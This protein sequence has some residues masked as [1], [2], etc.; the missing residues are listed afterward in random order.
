MLKPWHSNLVSSLIVWVKK[1]NEKILFNIKQDAHQLVGQAKCRASKIRPNAVE[2]W[3]FGRFSNFDKCRPEVA[4]DVIF[5]VA[6]TM[7]DINLH[8]KFGGSMLKSGRI[9]RLLSAPALRNFAQYLITFCSRLEAASD[10]ISG[11]IARPIVVDKRVKLC[12]PCLKRSRELP[13]KPLE[14]AFSTRFSRSLPTRN[15]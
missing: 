7:V 3:F 11:R 4:D 10:V 6:E 9:I 14:A 1:N 8:V 13:S 5:G 2:G 15:S 12:H